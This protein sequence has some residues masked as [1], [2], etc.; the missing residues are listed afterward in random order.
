MKFYEAII[1]DFFRAV[2]RCCMWCI[3]K[4]LQRHPHRD[5]L[6]PV[7]PARRHNRPDSEQDDWILRCQQT[8]VVRWKVKGEKWKELR[9]IRSKMNKKS[10]ANGF[11][12]A[13]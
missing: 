9:S 7:R 8:S 4:L 10:R 11:F 1:I 2:V 3:D 12:C 6:Q 13:I 5:N